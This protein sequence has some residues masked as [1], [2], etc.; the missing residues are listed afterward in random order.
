MA[1]VR[2]EV[3]GRLAVA[4]VSRPGRVELDDA[5]TNVRALVR[6]GHV[7]VLADAGFDPFRHTAGEVLA[8]LERADGSERDRVLELER[9]GKARKTVLAEHDDGED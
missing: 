2:C 1:R 5:E 3:I 4:G 8:Y 9:A 7:R 6:A